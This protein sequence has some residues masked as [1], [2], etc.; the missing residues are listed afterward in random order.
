MIDTLKPG[1]QIRCTIV[2]EPN[3]DHASSTVLRLMRLDPDIKRGLKHAQLRR[4]KR[5]IVRSRGGRPW[6]VREKSSKL[7][8][9]A[10]GQSW[11]MTWIPHVA[12][13]FKSVA[14][15]LKIESV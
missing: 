12:P 11:T 6:A 4:M 8:H 9:T 14:S 7:A 2:N 3:T 10:K 1:Q 13:D 15:F 5:L